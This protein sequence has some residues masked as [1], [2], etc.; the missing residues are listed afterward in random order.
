MALK[1]FPYSLII[2]F[3][4]Q[5]FSS[6]SLYSDYSPSQKQALYSSD[7][8]QVIDLSKGWQV[9]DNGEDWKNADLPFSINSDSPIYFEKTIK[10]DKSAQ[11]KYLW[12]LDFLG[13][14]E[15]VEISVNGSFLEKYF[16]GGGTFTV[17]IP[18]KYLDKEINTFRLKVYPVSNQTRLALGTHIYAPEIKTGI[19]RTVFLV[20]KPKIW[21]NNYSYT[22]KFSSDYET[23]EVDVTLSISSQ[24]GNYLTELGESQQR[25]AAALDTI[26]PATGDSVSRNTERK[27]TKAATKIYLSAE[28]IDSKG[29]VA[30]SI[31]DKEIAIDP[32]RT[33]QTPLRFRLTSP[34][35]WQPSNPDLYTVKFTIK[36]AAGGEI[37]DHIEY[38]LGLKDLRTEGNKFV[39]N[40]QALQLKGVNYTPP[41]VEDSTQIPTLLER[42]INSLKSLGAN[43]I[44]L[45]KTIPHPYLAH[46]CDKYGIL[47]MVDLPADGVPG[48]MTEEENYR[49][50]TINIAERLIDGL[51]NRVSLM[52]WGIHGD[53]SNDEEGVSFSSFLN[54]RVSQ[55]TKTLKYTSTSGGGYIPDW[56]DFLTIRIPTSERNFERIALQ[57]QNVRNEY[58]YPILVRYG[59]AV[60]TQHLYGWQDTQSEEYQGHYLKNIYSLISKYEGMGSIV[61]YYRDYRLENPLLTVNKENLYMA[62]AGLLSDEGKEKVAYK[63][64]KAF[65]NDEKQPLISAGEPVS[66]SPVVFTIIS[67]VLIVVV[68]LMLNRYRRFR[69]YFTRSLI[70]PFNFYSD[71]RDQRI[72]STV[73]TFIIG[74]IVAS[75]MALFISAIM[76]NYK[77]TEILQTILML[78]L[79]FKSAQDF[80]FKI[81]W[82]PLMMFL[83]F[84]SLFFLLMFIISLVLKFFSFF[85]RHRILFG[86]TLTITIWAAVPFLLMLPVSM[87]LPKLFEIG[88]TTLI[89]S[90][91]LGLVLG[92]W[93]FLRI[94][95]ATS[96]VFDKAMPTVYLVG[97]G[98][99]VLIVFVPTI[100]YQTNYNFLDYL[101]YFVKNQAS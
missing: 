46:L 67:I 34:S 47:M 4:C 40:G 90:L 63:V 8:R 21:I 57:L 73:R 29:A 78:V 16:G 82:E 41:F 101:G 60:K 48:G 7:T 91:G 23:A 9:S 86:D 76:Y 19:T 81:S 85:S 15:E 25:Q 24:K 80:L 1:S 62:T 42:D 100:I 59:V 43:L 50:R 18:E 30:A 11:K 64:M 75:S 71:I 87:V 61:D 26:D 79:P 22:S 36:G 93:I 98:V 89:A 31:S 66:D 3:I 52:A 58:S 51:E 55:L 35:L 84:T 28:L 92:L 69:E 27:P 44:L 49:V 5:I 95:N 96:I 33:I 2:L 10:L 13:L 83:F 99:L 72:M 17:N 6:Q 53:I 45:N 39:L 68:L 74:F 37:I 12:S 77:T 14:S 32:D 94:L 38:K 70:R 56:V 65:Y 20:G 54:D 88:E 97:L